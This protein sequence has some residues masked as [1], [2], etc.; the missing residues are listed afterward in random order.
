MDSCKCIDDGTTLI[1]CENCSL[2]RNFTVK[3]IQNIIDFY[4][5]HCSGC[6]DIKDI[7]GERFCTNCMK[8]RYSKI[9]DYVRM[10]D[11]EILP[12]KCTKSRILKKFS[13]LCYL[14]NEFTDKCI[15]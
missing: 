2:K 13:K 15:D 11:F 5:E 7:E 4:K 9:C 14:I 8:N 10:I 3:N 6:E 1:M 12:Y